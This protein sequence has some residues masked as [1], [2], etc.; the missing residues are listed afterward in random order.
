MLTASLKGEELNDSILQRN[1]QGQEMGKSAL[2]LF[3]SKE[4]F[5]KHVNFFAYLE[6][7]KIK[8]TIAIMEL[9]LTQNVLPFLTFA[10]CLKK[11]C[12]IKINP[13]H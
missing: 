5:L 13:E 6:E 12:E 8:P 10:L 1:K 7:K 9:L 3:Q 2:P 4:L 11:N